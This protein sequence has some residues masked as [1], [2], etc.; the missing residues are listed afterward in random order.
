VTDDTVI[1]VG[2][3]AVRARGLSDGEVNWT[4]ALDGEQPG[5]AASPSSNAGN[6]P[7]GRGV[8]A[9]DRYYLPVT[10][11]AVL[12][13]ELSTGRLA[14][15]HKSPRE[16]TTGNLI[17]HRGLFVSQ[18]PLALEVFDERE[19]LVNQVR[20]QLERN[21]QDPETLVRRGELELSA[22]HVTEAITAFRT[23]HKTARS[24]KTRTRL[25]G[26][27]LDG[28]R[29]KLPDHESLVAELDMLIGP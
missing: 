17:W 21:P 6:F 27:L 18:G 7:A 15:T 24:P 4:L 20:T 5:L 3:S 13:I 9:L 29:H 28:V 14:A 2:R 1:V 25:I 26:A 10:S 11:A 19:S 12:E 22:G 8:F 23:A 16:L